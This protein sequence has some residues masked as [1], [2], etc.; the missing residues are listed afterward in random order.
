MQVEQPHLRQHPTPMRQ[1]RGR[2]PTTCGRSS[3]PT[4]APDPE[5]APQ[6]RSPAAQL[7][8]AGRL[9]QQPTGCTGLAPHRGSR[10]AHA[11]VYGTEEVALDSSGPTCPSRGGCRGNAA[12][13]SDHQENASV[14]PAAALQ[15]EPKA[16]EPSSVTITKVF[17]F[18]GEE[19]R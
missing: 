8:W 9:H 1:H 14:P 15:K 11:R 5:R 19:I 17:D 13:V 3:C 4:W 2:R 16:P 7:R 18:A 10:H 6:G 12:D